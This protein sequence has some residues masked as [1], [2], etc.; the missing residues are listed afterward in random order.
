MEQRHDLGRDRSPF[1]TN[2]SRYRRLVGRLLYLLITRLDLTFSVHL[3]SQFMQAPREAHW[4]EALR[5]VRFLKAT[6]GQGVLF[7]SDKDLTLT[8]YSDSDWNSCPVSR[9]SLS[10]YVMLLGG[11][12]VSWKK[13]KQDTVARS[14]AEAEY[15]SMRNALDEIL[16]FLELLKEIG[17]PQQGAVRLFCDSQTAIYIAKNPVFHE[18]TKHVESDCHA[19][20]DAVL[21]GTISTPHVSTHDQLA[22][23]L[24]KALGRQQFEHLVSKLS[25]VNLHAPT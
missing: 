14:S 12:L 16:W 9:R 8:A 19:V 1:L 15:H 17:F 10:S 13:K 6:P 20:R 22:D 4:E 2:P 18:R 24:T 11:S 25:I 3:L 5:V 21:D 23:L 7:R